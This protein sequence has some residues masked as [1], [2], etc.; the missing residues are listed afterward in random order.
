MNV[1][2]IWF[3]HARF[4]HVAHRA[5]KCESCHAGV[6]QSRDH[7]DVLLPGIATCLQCHGPA[8]SGPDGSARGGASSGCTECH[9]YH[10][11]DR[12]LQGLGA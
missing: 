3:Q 2:A 6:E 10:N 1:P 11:G 4:D 8:G 12:S 9:R 5:L 7:H